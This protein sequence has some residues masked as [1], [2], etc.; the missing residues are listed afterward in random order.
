L[1]VLAYRGSVSPEDVFKMRFPVQDPL[2]SRVLGGREPV[3][4]SDTRGSA[5]QAQA[6]RE[7]IGKKMASTLGHIRSG[8]GVPLIVKN[9]VIGEL[10]LDHGDP[11]HFSAQDGEL[12]MTFANQVAV[13]IEN[14]RLYRRAQQAAALE[15]RQRIARGLQDSVSQTL[16]GISARSAA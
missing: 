12:V 6:Y 1:V 2:D 13:A 4:V 9:E 11:N 16:Y 3:I 10:A 7:S 5:P 8:M 15:E 14:A